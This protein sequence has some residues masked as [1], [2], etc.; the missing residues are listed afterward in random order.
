MAR[1]FVD[2]SL[3]EKYELKRVA[4]SVVGGIGITQR[5]QNKRV[6]IEF[7]TIAKSTPFSQ[8]ASQNLLA[9]K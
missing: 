3:K 6:Y 8:T 4:P 9:R 1:S 7:S 5:N 2:T